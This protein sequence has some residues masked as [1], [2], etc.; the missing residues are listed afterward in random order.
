MI[1]PK[2]VILAANAARILR[3]E[4][5]KAVKLTLLYDFLTILDSVECR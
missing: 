1:M 3:R 2:Q 5:I 4:S